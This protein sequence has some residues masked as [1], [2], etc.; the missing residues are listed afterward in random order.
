V[1]AHGAPL[2]AAQTEADN[3][4]LELDARRPIG[5]IAHRP[6]KPTQALADTY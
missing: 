3:P 6:I 1:A 2:L 5:A 4:W